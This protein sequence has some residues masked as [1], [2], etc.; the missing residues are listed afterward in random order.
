ML[1]YICANDVVVLLLGEV[2]QEIAGFQVVDNH[3]SVVRARVL[4]L[5]L[6]PSEAVTFARLRLSQIFT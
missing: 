5:C 1:Q 4:C 6:A 2:R 3:G